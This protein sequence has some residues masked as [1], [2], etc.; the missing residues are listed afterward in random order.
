MKAACRR[1]DPL[2]E[3][4]GPL[5]EERPALPL[6]VG[7]QNRARMRPLPSE[8][9]APAKRGRSG[10]QRLAAVGIAG[11]I[12]ACGLL[13]ALAFLTPEDCYARFY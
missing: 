7:Q 1:W 11:G 5:P 9:R 6:D 12:Y 8:A 4:A 3:G 10:P 13:V 2:G